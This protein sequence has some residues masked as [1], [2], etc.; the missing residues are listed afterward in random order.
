[1]GT[2]PSTAPGTTDEYRGLGW[3]F[4][5]LTVQ[6]H[7]AMLAPVT[8]VL[9]DG[10]QAAPM[11]IAPWAYEPGAERIAAVERKLRGDWPCLPF[12]YAAAPE[13]FPA[14]WAALMQPAEAHDLPHGYASNHGWTWQEAP[15]GS[16]A[17]AIDIPDPDP[18]RRMERTVTPDPSAPAVDITL[19]V[20]ARRPCRLPLGLH[21]TFRLPA[22]PGGA[23]IEPGAFDHGLTYLRSVDDATP[24]FAANQRFTDLSAVPGIDGGTVDAAAVPLAAPTEELLQLNGIDGSVALAYPDEGFRVRL[25]WQKE[26]L[27]S[28]LLWMS[29]RGRKF[30]PWNGRHVALGIEPICSPFGLGPAV[31]AA[32]NPIAR[33]GT[34]TA[35]AF[36]PDTPFVT[37]YRIA[38]EPL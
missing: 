17:L 29:N 7:A 23:R 16:L 30:H 34:P 3:E 10:R 27:P 15:A 21:P 6:R 14:E 33:S 13:G 38:A 5:S 11:Q 12:G 8:F 37:R 31:A 26:H 1:M 36:D 35:I 20:H 18:I 24:V 28:L 25:S 2:T 19:T 9:A 32:D 22:R 4:G